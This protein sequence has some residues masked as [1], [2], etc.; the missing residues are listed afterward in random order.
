MLKEKRGFKMEQKKTNGLGIAGMVIGIIALLL[1]CVVIGGFIGI[2]GL[3]LSLVGVFQENRKKGMAVTGIVLNS[4][5]I[6]IMIMLFLWS[7]LDSNTSQNNSQIEELAQE[8]VSE[9]KI[10][11]DKEKFITS[12]EEIPYK[13]L[14]RYPENNEG[15]YITLTV[16][17]VQVIQNGELNDNFYYRVYTDSTG[18]GIYI[19]DEYLM[20]DSRFNDATRLL[21]GDVIKVYGKFIGTA[22]LT[23]A[24]TGTVEYVPAITAYYIDILE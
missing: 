21:E 20:Y 16:Q 8:F 2:I 22:P 10:I 11:A 5:A 23:R 15:K 24:L 3:I 1:S 9:A 19:S 7:L 18:N 4:V 6:A 14:A 13:T 17:I 12:C